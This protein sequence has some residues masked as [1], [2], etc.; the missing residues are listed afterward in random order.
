MI[1]CSQLLVFSSALQTRHQRHT[2]LCSPFV[3]RACSVGFP[4][5]PGTP[6][7]ISFRVTV[8]CTMSTSGRCGLSRWYFLSRAGGVWCFDHVCDS[9]VLAL[10][11]FTSPSFWRRVPSSYRKKTHELVFILFYSGG[12]C[13]CRG[14][15]NTALGFLIAVAAARVLVL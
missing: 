4:M 12:C 10:R 8:A 13:C 2:V 9:V 15:L 7:Y 3:K 5:S 6:P 11:T 14:V 1:T